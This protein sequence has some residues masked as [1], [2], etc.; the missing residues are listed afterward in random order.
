VSVSS[1]ILTYLAHRHNAGTHQH[2]AK[3]KCKAQ[4]KL[5]YVYPVHA[6]AAKLDTRYTSCHRCVCTVRIHIAL[7]L[8]LASCAAKLRFRAC[9]IMKL[10]VACSSAMCTV[11]AIDRYQLHRADRQLYCHALLCDCKRTTSKVL[12][13]RHS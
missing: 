11:R 13:I 6:R 7:L 9:T 8:L 3:H 12:H 5:A 1:C 4:G 10:E 2:A